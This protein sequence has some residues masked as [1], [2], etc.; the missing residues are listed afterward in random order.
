MREA[1]DS[2]RDL[3]RWKDK[4]E[5]TLDGRQVFFLFFGGAVVACLLFVCGVL[6]GK[7]ME[8]RALAM[9][10]AAQSDPLAALDQ[11]GDVDPADEALT[12]H[13][14][15]AGRQPPHAELPPPPRPVAERQAP[16]VAAP[17]AAAPKGDRY[18][19]QLSA[20]ADKADADEFMRKVQALGYRPF[21]VASEVPG[22][23]VFYRVRVGDYATRQAATDAKSD[24]EKKQHLPAYV[25]RL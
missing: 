12:Y 24:I 8:A 9:T 16:A 7:R 18:T 4:V 20:F 13:K 3:H 25:A 5:L 11:L 17:P 19:L 6:V 22:R 14:T 23:G 21:V 10:P 2:I 1:T 15:L